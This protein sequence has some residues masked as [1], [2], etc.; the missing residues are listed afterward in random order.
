MQVPGHCTA[1]FLLLATAV[2]TAAQQE[3]EDRTYL[4]IFTLVKFANDACTGASTGRTGQCLAYANCYLDGGYGDGSCAEGFGVCCQFFTTSCTSTIS[5]N[6]TYIQNPGYPSGYTTTGACEF[7]ISKCDDSVCQV[8]LDFESLEL[9]DPLR[10]SVAAGPGAGTCVVDTLTFTASSG[11]SFGPLCGTESGNSHIYID[12]GNQ[13]GDNVAIKFSVN[14]GTPV[15]TADR[16]WSLRVVQIPCGG[17]GAS[18]QQAHWN[19]RQWLTGVAGALQSFNW[20]DSSSPQW[21]ASSYTACVRR[22]AGYCG[23]CWRADTSQTNSFQTD[24][25]IA[26]G[27]S[28]TTSCPATIARVFIPDSNAAGGDRAVATKDL[29]CGGAL[30]PAFLC[31]ATSNQVHVSLVSPPAPAAAGGTGDAQRG[32]RLLWRQLPCSS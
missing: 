20:E 1:V 8:R 2:L 6:L 31:S 5:Q 21:I 4:G 32:F 12:I 27:G 28:G 18:K 15:S 22:E 13:P 30:N 26:A 9:S 24:S 3:Q 7:F 14:A 29:Y 11:D 23:L 19:C 16:F 25:T 10:T 17:G